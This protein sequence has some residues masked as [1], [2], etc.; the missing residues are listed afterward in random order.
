MSRIEFNEA[1]WCRLTDADKRTLT[2]AFQARC[3]NS[4]GLEAGFPVYWRGR[5]PHAY[6]VKHAMWVQDWQADCKWQAFITA[7]GS[8]VAEWRSK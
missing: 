1:D 2:D 5:C 6:D 4:I 7:G 8:I 3:P